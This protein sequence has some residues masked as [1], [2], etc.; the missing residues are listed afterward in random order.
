[1][2]DTLLSCYRF[3]NC[4]FALLLP[5]YSDIVFLLLPQDCHLNW[6]YQLVTFLR[7]LFSYQ[8]LFH[9][10]KNS[11]KGV[12]RIALWFLLKAQTKLSSPSSRLPSGAPVL[13]LPSKGHGEQG[14][15]GWQ[16]QKRLVSGWSTELEREQIHLVIAFK[17]SKSVFASIRNENKPFQTFLWNTTVL[18]HLFSSCRHF[19][20]HSIRIWPWTL[21]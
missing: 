7:S 14:N 8:S 12:R 20:F 6:G 3:W 13:W 11:V 4:Q 1:M 9:S 5:I 16:Q 15:P 10:L 2:N 17:V 21:C 18:K 19:L